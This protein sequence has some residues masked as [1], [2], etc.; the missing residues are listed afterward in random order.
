MKPQN[1]DPTLV[2]F[3]SQKKVAG[4]MEKSR[5]ATADEGQGT[6]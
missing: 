4:E 6:D 5:G 2:H 1:N 3:W